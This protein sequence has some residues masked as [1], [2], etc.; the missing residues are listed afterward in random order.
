MPRA[1]GAPDS[2][3]VDGTLSKDI[4]SGDTFSADIKVDSIFSLKFT[5]QLCGANCSFE[6][7]VVK[8]KVSFRMPDCPIKAQSLQ[9]ATTLALP[10]TSP[11]PVK[12]GFKGKVQAKDAAGNTLADIDVQGD[13]SKSVVEVRG[14]H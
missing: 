7:P 12:I 3:S 10:A 9:N 11:V 1:R 4:V 5:C 14:G 6:V 13:V 2:A 8:T